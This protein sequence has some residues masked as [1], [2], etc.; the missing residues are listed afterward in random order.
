MILLRL[1]QNN[2]L[3]KLTGIIFLVLTLVSLAVA[4]QHYYIITDKT[5]FNYSLR[6]HIPFNFVYWH[7][8]T[9]FF[10]L[11][12]K[13]TRRFSITNQ[14]QIY[15]IFFYFI[16]PILTIFIH[17]IISAV[18]I[19]NVFD[20]P[21]LLRV[22]Y[23]RI[24]RNHWVWI[25]LSIYLAMLVGIEVL[26]FQEKTKLNDLKYTMLESQLAQSRLNALESQLHPHFLFN[27]LNTLSTLILK[28]DNK[29][30]GRMLE[31]LRNF[32][33][34]T[35]YENEKQ[36]ISFEEEMRFINY[37]LEIEKVR[38]KDK[39]EVREELDPDTL[40]ASVPNFLLQPIVEN[41]IHHGIARK[42]TS[43]LIK[44]SAKKEDRH[45]SIS[46]EDNGPGIQKFSIGKKKDG[47]GL[48]IT[49]Q[50]L[51]QL[52]GHNQIFELAESQ[53]GGLKVNLIIPFKEF[54]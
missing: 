41:A 31:L 50:R 10:I 26:E 20:D 18:I 15:W 54:N 44:I 5:R 16:F 11:I 6:W 29:E 24:F 51:Q 37:Y 21:D 38:F 32:L 36:Q 33:R 2:L 4:F 39:L 27:T 52:F 30:A 28:N 8:W 47:V 23:N 25:D 1:W 35:I 17:Q 22:L 19:Q 34:T 48:K 14:K 3:F 7:F 12:Y 53:L 40:N 13:L 42:I 46:I 49:R 43:G 9:L 45:L